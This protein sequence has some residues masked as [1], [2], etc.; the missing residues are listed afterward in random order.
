[1]LISSQFKA[2]ESTFHGCEQPRVNFNRLS[3]ISNFHLLGLKLTPKVG[4]TWAQATMKINAGVTRTVFLAEKVTLLN[5]SVS[6]DQLQ[7]QRAR[8]MRIIDLVSKVTDAGVL[9][10]AIASI[11]IPIAKFATLSFAIVTFCLQK[12]SH[13]IASLTLHDHLRSIN[14]NCLEPRWCLEAALLMRKAKQSYI[15]TPFGLSSKTDLCL[16]AYAQV[17]HSETDAGQFLKIKAEQQLRSILAGKTRKRDL[18]SALRLSPPIDVAQRVSANYVQKSFGTVDSLI[19]LESSVDDSRPSVIEC[20]SGHN[21]GSQTSRPPLE[22]TL[23]NLMW[24]TGNQKDWTDLISAK[25]ALVT[26]DRDHQSRG[27]STQKISIQ[28]SIH[29]LLFLAK[30]GLDL[31]HAQNFLNASLTD[32]MSFAL[33]QLIESDRIKVENGSFLSMSPSGQGLLYAVHRF[34][35]DEIDDSEI[36]HDRSLVQCSVD[37]LKAVLHNY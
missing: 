28:L 35:R 24:H 15:Q 31:R 30:A 2:Y 6:G 18:K 11:I 34:I 23:R 37:Q 33:D 8:A 21:Y 26:T 12:M 32:T 9:A 36:V 20:L 17:R 25:K 4:R 22:V 5:R 29:Q 27:Q 16:H 3:F 13:A 7:K 19:P 10:S 14:S 1:M